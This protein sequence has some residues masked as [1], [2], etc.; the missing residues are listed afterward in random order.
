MGSAALNQPAPQ[1][2][3]TTLGTLRINSR[4]W[5][6]LF[7]DGVYVGNTPQPALRLRPGEHSVRLV[8]T[9]FGMS[10]VFT[11]E[12][13]AGETLTRVE[14]LGDDAPSVAPSSSHQGNSATETE[15]HLDLQP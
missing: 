3:A 5:A 12:L 15:L 10:R 14:T 7:I 2:E 4:P 6:L 8:N 11:V 1:S 9:D 13:G